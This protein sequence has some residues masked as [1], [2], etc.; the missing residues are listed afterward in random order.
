MFHKVHTRHRMRKMHWLAML[1][2]PLAF[3]KGMLVG[4]FLGRKLSR[5]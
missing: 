1:A 5:D 4:Q 2:Y 3:L